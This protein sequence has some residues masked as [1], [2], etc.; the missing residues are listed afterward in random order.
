MT[1][2][3]FY[4]A[5][6][7]GDWQSINEGTLK[8]A[9]IEPL[10]FSRDNTKVYLSSDEGGERRCLIEQTLATGD[11]KSLI[12]DDQSDLAQIYWSFDQ[13]EVIAGWFP[14][15]AKQPMKYIDSNSASSIILRRVQLSFPGEIVLPESTALNGSKSILYVFSDRDPGG[16]YLFDVKSMQISPIAAAMDKIVPDQQGERRTVTFKARDGMELHAHFNDSAGRRSQSHADGGS[17]AWWPVWR[18]R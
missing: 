4:R 18:Q 1:P 13:N 9:R 3:A 2:T 15:S 14:K 11:R 8:N 10:A 6:P 7:N 12:C 16:Y 5:N 17:P